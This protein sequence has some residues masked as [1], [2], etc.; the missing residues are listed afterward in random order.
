LVSCTSCETGYELNNGV[1]EQDNGIALWII[2]VIVISVV[3]VIGAIVIGKIY[4]LFLG[5]VMYRKKKVKNS[6]LA[7][8]EV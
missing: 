5:C 2:I 1:C 4:Y 7:S 6:L 8:E 3:I